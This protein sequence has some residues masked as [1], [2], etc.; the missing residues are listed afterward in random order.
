MCKESQARA[1]LGGD[2]VVVKVAAQ[3]ETAAEGIPLHRPRRRT[4]S[5]EYGC[6][7]TVRNWRN[8]QTKP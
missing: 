2:D 4:G 6:T 1:W 8:R 3:A 7:R 5:T